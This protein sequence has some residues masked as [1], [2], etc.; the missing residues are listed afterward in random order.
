VNSSKL[1]DQHK[2]K[3]NQAPIWVEL[4]FLHHAS[5]GPFLRFTYTNWNGT[6]PSPFVFEIPNYCQCFLA[7][8]EEV[9]ESQDILF[10]EE[11]P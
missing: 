1:I 9:E 10:T 3:T 6:T 5:V 11:H 7:P 2:N 8:F 4:D